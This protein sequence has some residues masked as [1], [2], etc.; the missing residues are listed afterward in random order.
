MIR[1]ITGKP[2]DG[3]SMIATHTI[4]RQLL[5]TKRQIITN[6]P[7]IPGPLWAFIRARYGQDLEIERITMLDEDQVKQFFLHRGRGWVAP[8]PKERKD[9]GDGR[10]DFAHCTRTVTTPHS[11]GGPDRIEIEES[12]V[13]KLP[14]VLYVIDEAHLHFGSR[15]WM[16]TAQSALFYLSQHRHLGDE[17]FFVTQH[18][19]QVDKALRRLTQEFWRVTNYGNRIP[20]GIKLPDAFVVDVFSSEPSLLGQITDT[21]TLR[22]DVEGLGSCYDTAGGVGMVGGLA[23]TQSKPKGVRWQYAMAGFA[24]LMIALFAIPWTIA[25]VFTTNLEASQGK[26]NAPRTNSV[27]VKVAVP[28]AVT[29]TVPFPSQIATS[30]P[31]VPYNPNTVRTLVDGNGTRA[32]VG[33]PIAETVAPKLKFYLRKGDASVLGLDNGDVLSVMDGRLKVFGRILVVDGLR[34]FRLPE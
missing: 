29:N 10:I 8:P 25:H 9:G 3:K 28:V 19:G 24:V 5:K 22:L 12:A 32:Q 1:F 2:G 30:Q 15:Q 21:S 16:D 34:A 23:D 4:V 26:L 6:V 11:D 18:V 20:F 27:P 14:S 31:F 13:A 17:V 7:I 33:P